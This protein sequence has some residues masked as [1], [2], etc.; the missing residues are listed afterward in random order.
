MVNEEIIHKGLSLN[1]ENEN[2]SHAP[3][4]LQQLKQQPQ[5][6][7]LLLL[8]EYESKSNIKVNS[9]FLRVTNNIVIVR[10]SNPTQ[11]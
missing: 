9:H 8:R 6:G 11:M 5:Q 7:H 4:N 1:Y 2:H 10:L 3:Q